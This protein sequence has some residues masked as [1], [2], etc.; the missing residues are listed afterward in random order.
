[1]HISD[2]VLSGQICAA[3]A[4]ATVVIAGLVLKKTDR[5]EIPKIAVMTAAFFVASLLHIRLG[6]ASV[7]LLLNGLVGVV[8]GLAA[9][10]A[11]MIA[12]LFQAVMFQHGGITTLGANTLI[13]GLP[14]IVSWGIFQLKG[15]FRGSVT[16]L[17]ILSF[18]GGSVAILLSGGLMAFVLVLAGSEFIATAKVIVAAHIPVALIEGVIT[19]LVVEFF[20][21]VKPELVQ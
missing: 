15:K 11:I 12:L 8:L 19:V 5:K 20:V 3:T 6:P 9:F 2:G 21:K 18:T 16:A 17:R 13:M 7:H 10:P 1:M 14:A 4:V